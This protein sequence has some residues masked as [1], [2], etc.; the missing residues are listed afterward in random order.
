VLLGVEHLDHDAYALDHAGVRPPVLVALPAEHVVDH[1]GEVVA[2][3]AVHA[4]AV[5]LAPVARRHLSVHALLEADAQRPLVLE[6]VLAHA[7]CTCILALTRSSWARRDSGS[8]LITR[9]TLT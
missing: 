8:P 3:E 7:P 6:A 4:V 1:L 9:T 5:G 2:H